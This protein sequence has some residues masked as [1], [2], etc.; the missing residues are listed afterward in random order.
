M[1][2]LLA[3]AM[4]RIGLLCVLAAFFVVAALWSARAH[5]WYPHACCNTQDC[6]PADDFHEKA[7]EPEPTR[8]KGGWRLH[9]GTIIA[10]ADAKPS[11]D[12]MFHACRYAGNPRN[13]VIKVDGKPC[14]WAPVPSF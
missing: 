5:S 11:P 4:S 1:T 6:H 2:D 13:A 10:D 14:F 12:G 3:R 9:D 7:R 8:V